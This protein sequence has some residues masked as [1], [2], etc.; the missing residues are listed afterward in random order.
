MSRLTSLSANAIQ[1]M[2]SPDADDSLAVLLTFTGDGISPPIRITDT[3]KQRLSSLTTDDEV[4][5]GLVSRGDEFIFI[6]FQITLP[7]EQVA[8][9]PR[10]Q[11]IATDVTRYLIPV[12]RSIESPPSVMI[13]LVMTGTPNTVEVAF[14]GFQLG[15]VSYNANQITAELL[16][17]S[18]AAEPF[19]QH[20]FTP[21]YF[22][23]LF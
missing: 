5:H 4:V 21:S 16:V 17:Q 13:E 20:T 1:A 18:L 19:P 3:A 14:S 15:G 8:S 22:P 9:A 10:C 11:L 12:L 7:D 2:L 23:G 6:P